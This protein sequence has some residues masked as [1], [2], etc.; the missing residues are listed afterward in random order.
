MRLGQSGPD[1]DGVTYIL[2]NAYFCLVH[3]I[4]EDDVTSTVT[5]NTDQTL[6]IYSAGASE[7]Y[8]S[9][10]SKQVE[11]SGKD[12][13]RGFTLVVG[14]STS[15][16]ALPFQVIYAGKSKCSLPSPD[17]VDYQKATW[18]LKFCIESGGSNHW[19][20]QSTMKTYVQNILVPYF[21]G[22]KNN[23]NQICIWQIDCW[24]VHQSEEFRHWMYKTYLWI[25]IHYVP[26]NCTGFFQPCDVG[27]QQVLKLAIRCSALQ[28]VTND[29]TE[30]LG[31]GI[32]PS[33]VIFEK[34]LPVV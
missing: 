15:G 13:K 5:V 33:K 17:A 26:A 12:E 14:I 3:T 16:E 31:H 29:T 30:Q 23:P 2:T 4:L 27:I 19:S 18:I 9:K 7:T 20:T 8:A 10:G 6:V 21:E 22:H 28:D 25:W 11:V 24:S 34:R 1:T 32:E